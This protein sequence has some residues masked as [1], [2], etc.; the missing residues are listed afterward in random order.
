[1]TWQPTDPTTRPNFSRCAWRSGSRTC[2]IDGKPILFHRQGKEPATPKPS[3]RKPAAHNSRHQDL[4]AGLKSL[5]L[6]G[7]TAADVEKALKEL[8]IPATDGKDQGKV[9]RAVFL[10]LK[11]QD[12]SP[13]VPKPKPEPGEKQ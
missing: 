4:L 7:V 11:R 10:H 5:G 9:L 2:G 13:L 1:M 6:T 3:R 8:Q 12:I